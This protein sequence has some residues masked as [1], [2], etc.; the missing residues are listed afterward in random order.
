MSLFSMAFF[1]ILKCTMLPSCREPRT[2]P[3]SRARLGSRP[4]GSPA[5]ARVAPGAS[6]LA[7]EVHRRGAEYGRAGGGRE[8]ARG[9]RRG[10]R[11]GRRAAGGQQREDARVYLA[12]DLE[13]DVLGHIH[14]HRVEPGG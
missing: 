12:L 10:G 13:V 9:G 7:E 2:G 11:R 3:I 6:G 5:H 4:L 8:A 1:L 14:Q